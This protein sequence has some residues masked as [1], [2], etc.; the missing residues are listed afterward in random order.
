MMA[1]PTRFSATRYAAAIAD[2][3][4]LVGL[5]ELRE[6]FLRGA[7]GKDAL[8]LWRNRSFSEGGYGPVALPVP[9]KEESRGDSTAR[10]YWYPGTLAKWCGQTGRYDLV[11]LIPQQPK[12]AGRRVPGAPVA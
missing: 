11:A 7:Y 3:T 1:T 10:P 5:D 4:R 12:R 9:D 6:K 8:A 2:R